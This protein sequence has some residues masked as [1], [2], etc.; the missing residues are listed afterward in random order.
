[1]NIENLRER[2]IQEVQKLPADSSNYHSLV[3]LGNSIQ[4][5]RDNIFLGSDEEVGD[6]LKLVD[7][8]IMEINAKL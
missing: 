3:I 8:R 4:N 7:D 2:F 6:I 1:M 5:V